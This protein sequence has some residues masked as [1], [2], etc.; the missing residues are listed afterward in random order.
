LQEEEEDKALIIK[1]INLLKNII[2]K[3]KKFVEGKGGKI[4]G[5]QK[6]NNLINS[7]INEKEWDLF[8]L[9]KEE[10]N[11]LEKE[12]FDEISIPLLPELNNKKEKE[13]LILLFEIY[14]RK[15]AEESKEFKERISKSS[16]FNK[17]E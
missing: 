14:L 7:E 15:L 13:E 8:G 6:E 16:K 4:I 11:I 17:K 2:Y 3:I 1:L 5:S 9:L 12:K 10:I